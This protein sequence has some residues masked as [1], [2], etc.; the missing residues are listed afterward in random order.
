MSRQM[1][2]GMQRND[3][4][5]DRY[6]RKLL[7]L[8]A[9]ELAEAKAGRLDYEKL[10]DIRFCLA[11]ETFFAADIFISEVVHGGRYEF[12]CARC[13]RQFE[14]LSDEDKKWFLDRIDIRDKF[15]E[16]ELKMGHGDHEVGERPMQCTPCFAALAFRRY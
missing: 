11:C 8:T 16:D 7:D 4:Y 9:R 10:E 15:Y 6:T 14:R 13:S 1:A 5:S 12:V 2:H 3:H